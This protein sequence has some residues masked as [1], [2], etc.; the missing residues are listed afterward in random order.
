MS[1]LQ[2]LSKSDLSEKLCD[3][4]DVDVDFTRMTK[5]DL[6]SL[7]EKFNELIPAFN[8]KILH[9]PLKDVLDI[10]VGGKPLRDLTLSDIIQK[11]KD[12]G[13]LGLGILPEIRREI[14][15]KLRG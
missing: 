2:K 15:R 12:H 7:I 9:Q 8:E 4:L 11:V 5:E 1:K 10:M 6:V 13:P 14:K 3:L